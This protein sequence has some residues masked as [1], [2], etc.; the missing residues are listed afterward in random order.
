[1]SKY[2]TKHWV[3]DND[4]NYGDEYYNYGEYDAEDD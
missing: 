1:M 2:N 3:D 4:E